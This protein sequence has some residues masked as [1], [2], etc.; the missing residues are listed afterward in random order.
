MA[1]AALG[2]GGLW[3]H[4]H[5]TAADTAMVRERQ[6]RA[7]RLIDPESS[8]A[9]RLRI[10]LAGEDDYRSGGHAAILAQVAEARLAG[11]PVPL[12]EAL[13]LAHHCVLGPE[14]GVLR[15]ELAQD[16]IAEA[17]RTA[18]R[19]DLLMGLMWR[20]AD[21]FGDGDPHALRS[22]EE[23]RGRPDN[24]IPAVDLAA[25]PQPA[26]PATARAES[27][28][29]VLDEVARREYK[30][31]LT[32]LE[33]E[34]D[35]LES[36]NDRERIAGVRAERDW[37]IAELTSA[38]GMGGRHRRFNGSAERARVAVGKAIRRALDRVSEADRTIGDELR[39]TVH[40][41]RFCSYCP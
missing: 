25:G 18:R 20:T 30:Q 1:R 9:F 5:R 37:L 6:R 4:E 22:L 36:M 15:R 24:E 40:T 11:D 33:A 26:D 7:L 14:H 13:S 35:E 8:L 12:A 31:R 29:P 27:H 39:A 16:L 34:I 32:D 41:G 23:L 2:L 10:R 21:L 3:V 17:S 19:G 28:Q 38:T